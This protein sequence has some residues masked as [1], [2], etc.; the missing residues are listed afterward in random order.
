M[1]IVFRFKQTLLTE[2]SSEYNI[3]LTLQVYV[4]IHVCTGALPTYVGDFL[5]DYRQDS[6]VSHLSLQAK[7]F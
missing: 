7:I 2:L 1:G 6:C 4:C 5:G 3:P